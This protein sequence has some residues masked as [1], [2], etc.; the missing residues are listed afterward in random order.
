MKSRPQP[1]YKSHNDIYRRYP[2][3]NVISRKH[4]E[5][6][7]NASFKQGDIEFAQACSLVIKNDYTRFKI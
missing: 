4:I 6:L 1:P 3:L 7:G 5:K 2:F